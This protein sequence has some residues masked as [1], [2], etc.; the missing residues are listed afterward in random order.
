MNSNS[1]ID[2]EKLSSVKSG[3]EF[4]YKDVVRSDFPDSRHPEGGA[5]FK[6]EV[7]NGIYP[8]IIISDPGDNHM[9]YKK[10]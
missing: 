10:L 1:H 9:V 2:L 6:E 5:A 8:E 3:H 7:E 4:E